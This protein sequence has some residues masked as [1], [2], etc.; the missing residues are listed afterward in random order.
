HPD[1]FHQFFLRRSCTQRSFSVPADAIR[2]LRDMSDD[3]DRDDLL[4]FDR[5][6]PGSKGGRAEPFECCLLSRSQIT[7]PAWDFWCG[8]WIE[9]YASRHGSAGKSLST[10]GHPISCHMR[11]SKL[12]GSGSQ[13]IRDGNPI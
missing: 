11:R 8:V 3:C 1:R 5:E 7:S 6:G 2:A 12:L 4:Y 10:G 13:E 9:L